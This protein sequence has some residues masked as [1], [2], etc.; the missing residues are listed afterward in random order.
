MQKQI[1]KNKVKKINKEI[2]Q[3]YLPQGV[4]LLVSSQ[5]WIILQSPKSATF[6]FQCSPIFNKLISYITKFFKKYK[7]TSTVWCNNSTAW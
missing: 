6:A 2:K 4:Y 5:D 3:G 7:H 1:I